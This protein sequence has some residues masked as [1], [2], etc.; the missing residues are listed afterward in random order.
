MHIL[1]V[2]GGSITTGFGLV[3]SV[4][5]LIKPI[6]FG[7]IKMNSQMPHYER[8]GFLFDKLNEIFKNYEVDVVALEDVFVSKNPSSALKLGQIRGAVMAC[9]HF[10]GIRVKEFPST[11]VKSA[12]TGNGR[13]E[14]NQVKFMVKKILGIEKDITS[15]DESDAL[16]LAI[17]AALRREIL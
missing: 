2:D 12:L 1:G 7:T 10:N 11:L 16:A 3:S 6:T 4:G 9:A 8:I 17:T 14:K 15:F 5:N 13:A